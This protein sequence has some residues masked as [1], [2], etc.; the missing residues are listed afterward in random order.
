[1]P[2]DRHETDTQRWLHKLG[3]PAY[4]RQEVA[5]NR[6]RL[7]ELRGEPLR[8]HEREVADILDALFLQAVPPEH[9]AAT[10]AVFT[11]GY[12]DTKLTIV[13]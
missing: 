5:E 7:A 12:H 1:L 2:D 8:G 11:T 13:N 10:E 3:D 4:W 6:R 9:I